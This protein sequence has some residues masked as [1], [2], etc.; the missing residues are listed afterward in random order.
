MATTPNHYF[1]IFCG[2]T[3]PRLWPQSRANH[4]KQFLT[5]IGKKSLI[6]QT[7]NRAK[8]VCPSKNIFIVSNQKYQEKL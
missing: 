2:G 7:L 6:E 4:P 1:V 3:G 5:L 8:K